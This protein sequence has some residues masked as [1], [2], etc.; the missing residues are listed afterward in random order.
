MLPSQARR[1]QSDAV[2]AQDELVVSLQALLAYW[3]G[4]EEVV[5]GVPSHGRTQPGL[6]SA[7]GYYVNVMPL[8]THVGKCSSFAQ[9]A[10][11]VSQ[12]MRRAKA[13]ALIPLGEV[14]RRLQLP[15]DSSRNGV[16]QVTVAPQVG[17]PKD[18]EFAGLKTS[19]LYTDQVGHV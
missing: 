14:V 11:S 10:T 7:V 8:R 17:T 1:K 18:L 6:K 3:S 2:R 15:R 5:V 13:H 9:L 19:G 16:F 12:H 4:Q